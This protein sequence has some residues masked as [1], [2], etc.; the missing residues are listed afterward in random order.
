MPNTKH[1]YRIYHRVSKGDWSRAWAFF[2]HGL[3]LADSSEISLFLLEPT[4]VKVMEFIRKGLYNWKLTW[5]LVYTGWGYFMKHIAKHQCYFLH[6]AALNSPARS[7]L[8]SN[9]LSHFTCASLVHLQRAHSPKSCVVYLTF[10][11]RNPSCEEPLRASQCLAQNFHMLDTQ[12]IDLVTFLY[13]P[14]IIYLLYYGYNY[15]VVHYS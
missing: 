4:W 8:S 5:D 12:A 10:W 14:K 1:K 7:C 9:P 15:L 13:F 11:W 2:L 6:E 3:Y